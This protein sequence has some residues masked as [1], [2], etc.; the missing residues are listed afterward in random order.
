MR[1]PPS[2]SACW[3]WADGSCPPAA[4]GGPPSRNVILISID[5]L[6][7][8]HLSSYGFP[9]L[10]TPHID[11]LAREGVMFRNVYSPVPVTLPAHA[12]MLT[13]TFPPSH[14]IRDN[15]HK[16]LP[17]SAVTLAETLKSR[18]FTTAAVV[19]SFVLDRRFNLSQG[20]DSYDDRFQA[21]HKIGDFNERKGDET[22]RLATQWL[23][24]HGREPFF[25]FV[26]YY[27]PHDPYEPPEPFASKWADDLYSGEVA[28]TDHGVG[29]VM[30]KLKAL[31]LYDS[32]LIVITGDHGEMLGEHG[33]M[34]HGFFIYE[35]ALKVPLIFRAPGQKA[36]ARQVDQPVSLIDIMPTIASLMG[37]PAQKQVP[38]LDL[39]PWL[40]SDRA[41]LGGRP[42]YAE[43]IAPTTYYGASSL[44]GVI[45]DRWK[46]IETS[47]PELYDLRSDPLESVNLL[48]REP[49]RANAM[50]KEIKGI[51]ATALRP[52][53]SNNDAALDP[54]ARE[55]LEALGYLSRGGGSPEVVFDRTREDPKDLIGFF[56]TDQRLSKLA[57]SKKYAEARALCDQMLR[58]RP[59]FADCHLQ[60]SRMAAE[61]GNLTAAY[62]SAKKAVQ[63]SPG[64]EKARLHLAGLLQSRGDLDGAIAQHREA[65]KSQPDSIEARTLLGRALAEKGR[66]DEA[67]STLGSAVAA[68]PESAMARTQMGFALAKQGKL[69]EAIESY[70]K[71]VAL[72]PGSA[73]AHAYLGS[74]LATQGKL[75]EA[76]GHFEEALRA[77]P[78]SAELHDWLGNAL[79]EKGR[80]EDAIVQFREA[81]RLDPALAAAHLNLGRALKQQ[82]NL[83]EA[84]EHYRRA[85]AINP[86]LAA[87]HN[88]LGSALGSLGRLSEAVQEFREALRVEPDYDEA[89][90]NLGRALRMMGER[91]QALKHFRA[92]LARRAD[93]SA[94]MTEIAWIL[95][96]HTDSRVRNPAE[97]VRLAERATELTSRRDAVAL[98]ALAAAYAAAGDWDRA[99][100]TAE[101]AIALASARS[102]AMAEDIAK[103]LALYRRKQPYRE[104][105]G[106]GSG[107]AR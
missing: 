8:D 92:A 14:G 47:R 25:L 61:E 29:E 30:E 9:R 23:A 95:A 17:D 83:D 49:A 105:S 62:E 13:G 33:E 84:V 11:A 21:V 26:H 53:G 20:F 1:G 52:Q 18:G 73:D 69:P 63:L 37:A 41:G 60:M 74:A 96:T 43:T 66:L 50:G 100:T 48:Q 77:R 44:L 82:G 75:D 36:A 103:R 57:E 12:S 89:H 15:L 46:Y 64:N 24:G 102:P 106:V 51:V 80:P 39:S 78:E 97:A 58:E 5:T 54:A 91:D 45:V 98:D 19:S 93:W 4:R 94:P 87:A 34:N 72:D 55:R 28:F 107:T 7:A 81:V 32:T 79:R 70:R 90:N 99:S 31:G 27:D 104:P 65:L 10:T 6:R 40:A 85:I 59:G 71:A 76:I 42:L 2:C 86:R 68:Q 56:R 16:R 3:A 38:G 22:T 67:V 88:N 35:S 101:A